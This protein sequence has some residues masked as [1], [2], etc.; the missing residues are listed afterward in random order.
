MYEVGIWFVHL[1]NVAILAIIGIVV[2]VAIFMKKR[3]YQRE[4]IRCI[5]AEILLSTGWPEYHIV[6]CGVDDEWVKIKG[7]EYK[8]NPEKTRWG[9]HPRVPFMGLRDLQV[10]IRKE[11]WYKDNPD[12][13]YRGDEVPTVTAAEVAAKTR[14]ATAVAVGA[15]AVELEARQTQLVEAITNQPNKLWVYMGLGAAFVGIL[16]LVIQSLLQ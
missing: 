15:E 1:M 9:L 2:L 6:K 7:F 5:Q 3:R 16:F 4:V 8:L 14:E 11:T 13:V 10:P 12:P